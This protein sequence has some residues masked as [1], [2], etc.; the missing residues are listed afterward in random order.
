MNKTDSAELLKTLRDIHEP[1]PPEPGWPWAI[2]ATVLAI[3][4]VTMLLLIRKK[5]KA[6]EIE[7][8]IEAARG[9]PYQQALTRLARLLRKYAPTELTSG[10]TPPRGDAWL[11]HLDTYFKTNY[12]SQDAGRIFGLA[13]YKRTEESPDINALC[14]QLQ[15]MLNKRR[16]NPIC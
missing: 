10:S 2:L 5:R 1:L 4:L 8:Q 3:V 12:F 16:R 13:L 14:N 7:Q 9:E 6:T 15:N 11:Q